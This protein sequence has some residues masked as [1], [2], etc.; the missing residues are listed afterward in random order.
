[1]G[2]GGREVGGG[3]PIIEN[4]PSPHTSLP[5]C[6]HVIPTHLIALL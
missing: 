3:A 4:W 2:L 1:M 6:D 5:C